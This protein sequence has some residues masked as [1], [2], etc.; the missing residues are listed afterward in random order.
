MQA[1]VDR[2]K[3]SRPHALPKEKPQDHHHTD[4]RGHGDRN[5]AALLMTVI[6]VR[7]HAGQ[8]FLV[9]QNYHPVLPPG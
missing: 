7:L 5:A 3:Y 1:E 8:E 2:S 6:T 9:V 4:S